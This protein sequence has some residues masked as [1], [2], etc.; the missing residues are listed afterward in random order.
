LR[1]DLLNEDPDAERIFNLWRPNG[2]YPLTAA[3][4]LYDEHLEATRLK[5]VA[6]EP[7]AEADLSG[8]GKMENGGHHEVSGF[9]E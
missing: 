3:A 1:Q 7:V 8:V 4:K 2:V 9:P 5:L 6:P